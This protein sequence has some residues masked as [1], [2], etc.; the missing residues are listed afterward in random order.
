MVVVGHYLHFWG[1]LV[2]AS[3]M[4]HASRPL[5]DT[6]W[7]PL[8]APFEHSSPCFLVFDDAWRVVSQL[9]L[10]WLLCGLNL[11][12]VSDAILGRWINH[13]ARRVPSWLTYLHRRML[14]TCIKRIRR[15]QATVICRSVGFRLS[16]WKVAVSN[17]VDLDD[18][19]LLLVS[20][21][22]VLAWT[23]YVRRASI[24][25]RVDTSLSLSDSLSGSMCV[26][27]LDGFLT[28]RG[29][30]HVCI[31]LAACSSCL[32]L[33]HSLCGQVS[34]LCT[35]LVWEMRIFR[36]HLKEV[37]FCKLCLA[38]RSGRDS[39]SGSTTCWAAYSFRLVWL[40]TFLDNSLRW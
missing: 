31:R 34:I 3:L 8:E 37:G 16:R 40:G 39:I 15:G 7:V 13:W 24:I 29:T 26:T 5:T 14:L 2:F 10:V 4:K 33:E 23:G 9:V 11:T 28:V 20:V 6:E 21:S 27:S 25:R 32:W 36:A 17:P 30:Y 12:W 18:T 38:Q 1:V 35:S 22:H 19:T